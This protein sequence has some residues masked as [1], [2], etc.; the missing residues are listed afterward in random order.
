MFELRTHV[1]ISSVNILI[2]LTSQTSLVQCPPVIRH[3]TGQTEPR[4]RLTIHNS[5]K[6][7][8]ASKNRNVNNIAMLSIVLLTKTHKI[9]KSLKMAYV[10]C[11]LTFKTVISSRTT[12][13]FEQFLYFLTATAM[14]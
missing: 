4:S 6:K 5:T 8:G 1:V 12:S 2:P 13:S 9:V 10:Q 14:P 7:T 11:A 3:L